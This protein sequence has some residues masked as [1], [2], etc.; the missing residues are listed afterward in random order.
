MTFR[1]VYRDGIVI[2]PEDVDIP[3]GSE[4][5]VQLR[6]AGVKTKASRKKATKA[7]APSKGSRKSKAKT[8]LETLAP[9]IGK[10]KWLPAD[11]AEQH[12]HY[13]HGAPKRR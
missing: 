13:I 10:A 9:V 11:F 3:N 6:R 8:L 12:D 4:V 2:M 1:G 5:D 7:T